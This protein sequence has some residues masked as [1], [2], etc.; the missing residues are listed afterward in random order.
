ME[1][2]DTRSLDVASDRLREEFDRRV[3]PET[4]DDALRE[5]TEE[6]VAVARV[7][8]FVPLLAERR[9]RER[10]AAIA[11]ASSR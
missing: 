4:I 6:L 1:I 7:D 8:N 9:T 10:L 5:S 11:G 2:L 3:P